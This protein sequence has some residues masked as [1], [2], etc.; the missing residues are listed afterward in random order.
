MAE[1]RPARLLSMSIELVEF[2]AVSLAR[3][4]GGS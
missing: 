1:I 2:A 3:E 4:D